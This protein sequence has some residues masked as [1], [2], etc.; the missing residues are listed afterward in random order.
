MNLDL[1]ARCFDSLM[2][3]GPSHGPNNFYVYI[4]TTEEPGVRKPV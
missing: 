4:S 1:Y 2:S 3:R